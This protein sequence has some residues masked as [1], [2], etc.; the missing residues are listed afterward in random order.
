MIG[1]S[2]PHTQEINITFKYTGES[3]IPAVSIV[4]V[5]DKLIYKRPYVKS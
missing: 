3:V 2:C 1:I 4:P 5:N